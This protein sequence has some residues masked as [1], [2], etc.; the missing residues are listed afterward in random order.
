[1]GR[2]DWIDFVQV[3]DKWHAFVKAVMNFRVP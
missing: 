1:M 2:M 3:G